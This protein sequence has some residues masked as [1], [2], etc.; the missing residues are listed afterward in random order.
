M[1]KAYARHG[2][3]IAAAAI[4]LLPFTWIRPVSA[5]PMQSQ[6]VTVSSPTPSAVT[7]H[8]FSATLQSV[9]PVGSFVLEYCNNTPIR[10]LPCGVPAG[11]D[12]SAAIL[13]SQSGETGFTIDAVNST[14][15][16][17]VLT[18]VPVPTTSAPITYNFENITNNSTANSTTFVRLSTHASTDG[19]GAVIDEGTAAYST[20]TDI[21]FQ[22][23]V[24]P[25]LTFCVGV[26]VS[27]NCTSFSGDLLNFGELSPVQPRYLS[28]QFAIATNDLNG[29]A[30][31]V[32]GPTML[33]GNNT[34][35]EMDS[36]RASQAGVSQFG[37]NLRANSNP[38]IG[39]DPFGSGTGVVA[40]GFNTPNQFYFNNQSITSSP[41]PSEFNVFTV[42]YIVNISRNQPAGIYATT[43]TYIGTAAF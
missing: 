32:S 8:L 43:L 39:S 16:K 37:M 41:I 42:S 34:I 36:P 4:A 20:N 31:Y 29:Y 14:P 5:L 26:Q 18:R 12:V 3:V 28:S 27:P 15:N 33:S 35:A 21:S 1:L 7:S 11:L 25:Y 19:S 23:Y 40:S 6:S 24:P 22:G 2:Y 38:S 30:T 13:Q 17:I 9:D 10:S